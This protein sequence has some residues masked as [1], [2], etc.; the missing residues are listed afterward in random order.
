[1]SFHAIT[2]NTPATAEAHITAEDDAAI[3]QAVFGGDCVFDIGSKLNATILS[4][5]KVRI[6]D[7]VICVGGHIGRNK[8]GDYED[9]TI[10]NGVSGKKRNDLIVARFSTTGAGGIDT[11]TLAVKQGTAGTTATDPAVTQGNLYQGA[12]LREFP[13]Y[14]VKIEGLSITAMNQLFTVRKTNEQ[15]MSE[16]TELNR[17]LLYSTSEV[18]IGVTDGNKPVYRKVVKIPMT[19]FVASSGYANLS[20]GIGVLA[21]E[22]FSL[23]A[24]AYRA[25]DGHTDTLPYSGNGTMS[26]WLA[27]VTTKNGE[28]VLNFVN[29]LEWGSAYTL[30]VTIEY[31]KS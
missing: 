11:F 10:A 19:Y 22:I 18:Q 12:A 30:I 6:G 16:L 24:Y 13:L 8:Y 7:G 1:M 15:M 31:T 28:T 23:N 3:Y 14:R 27:Y 21:K 20:Q 9:L 25:S 26:T 4:N 2:V 29:K 17:K 5:N